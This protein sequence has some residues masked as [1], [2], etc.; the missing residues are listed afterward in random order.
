MQN[1]STGRC[2]SVKTPFSVTDD[3]VDR[4]QVDDTFDERQICVNVCG[5]EKNPGSSAATC[6]CRGTISVGLCAFNHDKRGSVGSSMSDF[7]HELNT[8][9]VLRWMH[10]FA[11]KHCE[12]RPP[13]DA[14]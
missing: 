8:E 4:R 11:A 7:E 3:S 6:P 5:V 13:R 12:P 9:W 2:T 1:C 14:G 10:Q